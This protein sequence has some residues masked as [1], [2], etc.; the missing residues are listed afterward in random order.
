MPGQDIVQRDVSKNTANILN[1][2][3]QPLI[4]CF[5]D[6]MATDLQKELAEAIVVNKKLPRDK[7]KNKKEL[8]V[9]MGYAT[10]T[11]ESIPNK[12]L[13]SKGVK[14]ALKEYGLTEK[15]VT[16]SLVSDIQEKPKNRLGELRL[17]SEILGMNEGEKGGNKT[18]VLI[19]SGESAQRYNVQP[20]GNTKTSSD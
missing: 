10:T 19:V 14:E 1:S 17:A 20:N 2:L 18:L 16:T 13:E 7:R 8:L 11:A 9:S 6:K 15:L 12:I 5:M 3:Y 4:S